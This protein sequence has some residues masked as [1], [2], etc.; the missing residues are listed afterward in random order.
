MAGTGARLRTRRLGKELAQEP[1]HAKN[2]AGS[3]RSTPTMPVA[4]PM[5]VAGAMPRQAEGC[6]SA[7]SKVTLTRASHCTILPAHGSRFQQVSR[8]QRPARQGSG[9]FAAFHTGLLHARSRANFALLVALL[10]SILL[11]TMRPETFNASL[12]S[13]VGTQKHVHGD[14]AREPLLA[15]ITFLHEA[16]KQLVLLSN[17]R[18]GGA[19]CITDRRE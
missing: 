11:M 18:N 7:T 9:R 16:L 15:I 19:P 4:R 1:P 10:R 2:G 6:K 14:L 3:G 8:W 13:F 17:V 5:P 12:L